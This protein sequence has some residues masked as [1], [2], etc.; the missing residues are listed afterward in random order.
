MPKPSAPITAPGMHHDTIPKPDAVAERDI[1]KQAAA[2]AQVASC[3][4]DGARP[5]VQPS[6]MSQ[7]SPITTC[8]PMLTSLPIRA[9]SAMTAVG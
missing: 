5:M 9:D 4:Q 2:C 6:P 1:G 3:F 8:A 7:S